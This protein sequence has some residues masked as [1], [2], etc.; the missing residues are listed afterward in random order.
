MQLADLDEVMAVEQTVYSHP[1]SRGNF[2]DVVNNDY[3]AWVVRSGQGE[4]LA[5]VVQ[6]QVLDECHLLT[7]AVKNSAQRQGLGRYLLAM[8]TERAKRMQLKSVILEVRVSNQIARKVYES[9]GFKL[10]GRRKNYYQLNQTQRE[11]ALLLGY[12]IPE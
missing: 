7:I 6:M 1:W 8:V 5:Y 12:E 11:D 10:L 4:L 9:S 3:E 2:V